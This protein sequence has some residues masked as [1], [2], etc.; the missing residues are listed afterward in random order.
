MICIK[1]HESNKNLCSEIMEDNFKRELQVDEGVQ[2]K[3]YTHTVEANNLK[4]KAKT[5]PNTIHQM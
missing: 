2:I 3:H 4:M 5:K 1:E